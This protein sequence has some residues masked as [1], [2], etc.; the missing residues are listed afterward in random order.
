M[1]I[2]YSLTV[3]GLSLYGTAYANIPSYV[4][5]IFIILYLK[6]RLNYILDL[7]TY[8]DM[9]STLNVLVTGSLISK[10]LSPSLLSNNFNS[11]C[12]FFST[13]LANAIPT[14]NISPLSGDIIV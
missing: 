1:S 13:D 2:L 11:L 14:V 7:H 8:L 5:S 4:T 3:S 9:I 10:L 12:K 6:L